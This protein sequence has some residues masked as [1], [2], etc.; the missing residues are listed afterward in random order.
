MPG[1]AEWRSN[2]LQADAMVFAPQYPPGSLTA[3][4]EFS[5]LALPLRAL[6]PVLQLALLSACTGKLTN[7]ALPPSQLRESSNISDVAESAREL[8]ALAGKDQVL[9]IYD[10]DNTLLAM[11]QDL[12]SDQWY[13]WQKDLQT[14]DRCDPRVVA[15]R[16]AAQG[17]LYF[18]SA[19]RPTQADAAAVVRE[20]QD[21]GFMS[22][23]LTSRGADFAASSFRELRRN[24]FDFSREPMGDGTTLRF[25]PAAESR[26][27]LYESGVYLTAG[28]D[29]GEML[30][31][32]LKATN[33][34]LPRAIVMA[35]DK[36]ENL[37][38]VLDALAAQPVSVQALRYDRE[39][40]R[41]AAFDGEK[42][43]AQWHAVEPALRQLQQAFG[44]DNFQLPEPGLPEGC[45]ESHAVRDSTAMDTQAAPS[46]PQQVRIA[47]FNIAMGFSKAGEMA[48]ALQNPQ[49]QRLQQVAAIL[50]TVRPDIVLL[51][52]FDYDPA[53]DAAGLLNRN[54]LAVA[55]A[56][57]EAIE[58]PYHF[59]AESNTGIPSG[60]DIDGDGK[61]DRPGD[62]WGFGHFPG[63]YG[64]LLLS[65]F[66]IDATQ[67]RTFQ[68]FLW[69]GLAGARRPVNPDGSHF[70]TDETWQQLRLS[71]KSHWDVPVKMG[72]QT[73]HVLAFHPTPPVFDGPE[74]RNGLRNFDEIRLW[75]D[76]LRPTVSAGWTDDQGR[77]GGLAADAR[78][79]I[80]G[81]VN[82]DPFTGDS[83]PGA[84][85]QLLE[86]ERVDSTLVPRSRGAAEASR[87]Q[88]GVNV[89]Q[90]GDASADTAD[91]D[92]RFTGNLRID[93]VLPSHTLRVEDSAVF[94]PA[95]DESDHELTRVSD[96]HLVWMDVVPAGGQ[97]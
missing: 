46:T 23:I 82:A 15:D 2:P 92:D 8:A 13:Y 42:A 38:A 93:Y 39:D 86:H 20:L 10:L 14:A 62:A 78:F 29:K 69:A 25:K 72:D 67:V 87:K 76:Y 49:H 70:Y 17:A 27:T 74:N 9:V 4:S 47:T 84:V 56:D 19:M 43:A 36:A 65:R 16:L 6:L 80:L 5:R 22:I 58:Y 94:W 90:K 31:A 32:L 1:L 24:G 91:F 21:E 83:Y 50:Q 30:L 85:Q 96:H 34:P 52:E 89:K 97:P 95:S 61:T 66:P 68:K 55:A 37:R 71:S 53:V 33:A 44:T 28:Q 51:N 64:M 54:F 18:A 35:D 45:S 26:E 81:D 60:L 40:A 77:N 88:A 59:R 11:E 48:A 63:Q 75:A 3:K 73:L 79:V 57:R 12:G 7:P 41:V